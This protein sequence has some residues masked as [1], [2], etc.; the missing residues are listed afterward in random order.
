M[1]IEDKIDTWAE[2]AANALKKTGGVMSKNNGGPA[3][4]IVASSLE[5]VCVSGMTLRDYFA[6]KAMQGFVNELGSADYEK[7]FAKISYLMADAMLAE[8]EKDI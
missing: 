8:R 7:E 1:N 6:A 4:P 5:H 3:F 2:E